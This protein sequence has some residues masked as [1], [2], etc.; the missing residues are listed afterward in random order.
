MKEGVKTG[1]GVNESAF[2]EEDGQKAPF[3]HEYKRQV[4]Y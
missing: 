3:P 2:L 1:L 4:D